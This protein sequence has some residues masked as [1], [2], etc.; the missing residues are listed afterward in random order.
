MLLDQMMPGMSGTQ[1][2]HVIR[3][4]R[5][6]EDTPIIVLTADAIVGA[7]DSYIREGFSDYLS[8]PIRYEELE[9]LLQKYID[10][11]L[12]LSKEQL[13]EE[14]RRKAQERARAEAARPVVLVVSGSAERLHEAKDLISDKY[15]GVFVK[16]EEQAKK[17]MDKHEVAFVIRDL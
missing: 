17:Y 14:E 12:I 10:T 8:K 2:L 7:R 3:E 6:A 1:T 9:T 13:E 4:K 15:K 11:G 16:D 5:L